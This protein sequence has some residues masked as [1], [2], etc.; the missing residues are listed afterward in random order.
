[1]HPSMPPSMVFPLWDYSA[2]AE[3]H[4]GRKEAARASFGPSNSILEA[5]NGPR[6][7]RAGPLV[8][9]QR[10]HG[11]LAHL[12]HRMINDGSYSPLCPTYARPGAYVES[13]SRKIHTNRACAGLSWVCRG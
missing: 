1:M 5:W 2:V 13:A 12:H 6:V 4:R 11:P 8:N 7:G 9:N 3:P 10:P